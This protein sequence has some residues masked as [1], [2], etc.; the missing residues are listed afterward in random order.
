MIRRPPRSTLFP[1]TTLFRSRLGPGPGGDA[2]PERAAATRLAL[3][4]DGAAVLL[5]DGLA[6][7]ET[8]T[9]TALLAG[10]GGLELLEAPEDRLALV[11]GDPAVVVLH[12]HLRPAVLCHHRGGDA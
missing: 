8:Q 7:G 10:V 5:D 1:Y 12:A 3:H 9:R 6:D 11:G 2:E 4:P